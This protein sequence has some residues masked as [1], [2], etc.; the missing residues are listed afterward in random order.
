MKI[1]LFLS[2]I[3]IF[4]IANPLYS[5]IYSPTDYIELDFDVV[6]YEAE[7]DL[8]DAPNMYLI[9]KN[10]IDFVW[11]NDK[12]DAKFYF[13]LYDLT[14]DSIKYND[15]SID[16]SIGESYDSLMNYT[17]K[18]Y[19]I[20]RIIMEIDTVRLTIYYQGKMTFAPNNLGWA[21]VNYINNILYA[22][23][24]GFSNP[25]VSATRHWLPCFDHPSDKATFA[26]KFIV[27]R[28]LKVASIGNYSIQ[29]T[30]NGKSIYTF[31]HNYPVAT[32]LMTF[33]VG[34]YEK[35]EMIYNNLPIH[36]HTL[37]NDK[38]ASNYYYKKVPEMLSS[39]EKYFGDYPFEKVGFVN[40][41]TG[42]ME[43]QT[44]ISMDARII[45]ESISKRDSLAT[46]AAH[47]L[48]HQ[49]F[50][51]SITPI[52]FGE[53]WLNEGFATYSEAL[54]MESNFGFN[55]YLSKIRQDII[56][57][58]GYIGIEGLLPLYNFD[59]TGNSSNYPLTI[60]KKGSAVLGMLRYKLGD[61]IFFEALIEYTNRFKYKNVSTLDLAA[62]YEDICNCD[63]SEFFEQ[64]VY[65]RGF[66][67][68]E[69]TFDRN[70]GNGVDSVLVSF[71]QVQTD[72]LEL[73][74]DFPIELSFLDI[75]ANYTHHIF[76]IT[77]K[78]Q[79]FWIYNLP[80]I[81][82]VFTNRGENVSPLIQVRSVKYLSVKDSEINNQ[83]IIFPNP[84]SDL[85]Y[86]NY[87]VEN[88]HTRI[89][90]SD[91]FGKSFFSLDLINGEHQHIIDVSNLP[92]GT[93]LVNISSNNRVVTKMFV[94]L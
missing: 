72:G 44:M 54:W 64:W 25:Y 26:G 42:S 66:P 34:N 20:E 50:G 5:H 87:L 53:A 12:I 91:I 46:T 27:N 69:I 82:S 80:P 17:H 38:A 19:I 32:Y 92:I 78:E 47:E 6:H 60:Y 75:D 58:L 43:H 16:F 41:P 2:L 45:R 56:Q 79:S 11:K 90:I 76:N 18:Y 48:A 62:T 49:W 39:F 83:I 61:S 22:M 10:S 81:A 59:R 85:L 86:I 74:K 24:V 84:T 35:I 57:Y 63:L 93:Y 68:L 37:P 51:N 14:I 21:G 30:D 40:T 31:E 36:I 28:D 94:K 55:S 71:N 33:A 15:N 29:E 77:E 3:A 52:H 89:N 65:S 13:H 67:I 8:K 9:G 23:G 73:F 1:N 7:L 70:L 88:H 4:F